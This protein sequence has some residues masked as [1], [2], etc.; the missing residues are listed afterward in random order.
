MSEL[1]YQLM[2]NKDM[3]WVPCYLKSDV[4]K[5]IKELEE[6]H[7]KEVEQLLMEIAGLK[8]KINEA[9]TELE[10]WRDG[11][12]ILETHQ[13][14]LDGKSH[15]DYKRCVAMAETCC[16]KKENCYNRALRK[17]TKNESDYLV[18]KSDFWENWE[19]RWLAIAEK[20]KHNNSTINR[21]EATNAL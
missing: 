20:F 10:L 13:K 1:K 2:L 15:S 7:K 12:I 21:K 9:Q 19:L 8:K 17:Y 5:Q 14:K 18:R 6:N 11:S 4:D 3:S 16:N